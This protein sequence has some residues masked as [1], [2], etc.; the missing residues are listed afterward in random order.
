MPANYFDKF[1][2]C[3]RNVKNEPLPAVVAEP[4]QW[5][6]DPHSDAGFMTL[7]P[8]NE[9]SGLAIKADDGWFS[10]EQEPQSFVVNAG[11][12]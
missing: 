2:T 8:T 10:V 3:S 5:G 6:I 12:T 7:L 4:D 9:V 11:D 1:L